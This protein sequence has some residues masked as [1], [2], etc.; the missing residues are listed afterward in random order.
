MTHHCLWKLSNVTTFK[1]DISLVST[2]T[3]MTNTTMTDVNNV[4]Q[5]AGKC[6]TLEA[7]IAEWRADNSKVMNS[8][9]DY[10]KRILKYHSMFHVHSVL[11]LLYF[12]SS[13]QMPPQCGDNQF[14]YFLFRE[15]DLLYNWKKW[16]YT[17]F[18]NIAGGS[19][20]II[21]LHRMQNCSFRSE[22]RLLRCFS[23]TRCNI[24]ILQ[25]PRQTNPK[26]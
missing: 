16:M 5:V 12:T 26:T 17:W 10:W 21:P 25:N 4:W 18:V 22:F 7:I 15:W 1:E 9:I 19:M 23:A 14:C 2:V 8:K 20:N 24:D 3:E 11:S 13:V 6:P